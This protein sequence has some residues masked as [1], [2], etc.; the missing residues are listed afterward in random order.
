MKGQESKF[1]QKVTFRPI[2]KPHTA[3]NIKKGLYS[4]NIYTS[5]PYVTKDS[6][7]T[8]PTIKTVCEISIFFTCTYNYF[9]V[10]S[11]NHISST[12]IFTT[13]LYFSK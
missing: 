5:T 8:P 2:K 10:S 4:G 12:V 7:L 3:Y 1:K 9:L 13:V 11:R 6:S